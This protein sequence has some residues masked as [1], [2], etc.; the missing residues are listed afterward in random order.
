MCLL[1]LL[2]VSLV[3]AEEKEREIK[4]TGI[5]KMSVKADIADVKL[6]IEVE[7]KTAQDVERALSMQMPSLLDSLK[8]EKVEK[9]E[10]GILEIHPEYTQSSPPEIKGYRGRSLV[11]FSS[12]TETAG[13]LIGKAF[14]AGAN[15]LTQVKVRPSD[16]SLVQA[17]NIVLKEA[18][19]NAV[20]E[21][22]LVLESLNLKQKEISSI[23]VMPTDIGMPIYRNTEFAMLG[24]KNSPDMKILEGEQI[25]QAQIE[26]AIKFRDK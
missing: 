6:G 23:I 20:I 2:S 3:S 24:A 21:A 1:I 25:V 13:K 11:S 19:Q 10:T 15:L 16:S 8:D 4:V 14:A 9:L 26:V 17:R 7:E 12:P 22:D 5:G 18:G